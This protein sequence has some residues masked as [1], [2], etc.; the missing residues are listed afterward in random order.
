ME[1]IKAL[2]QENFPAAFATA[3]LVLYFFGMAI[4]FISKPLKNAESFSIKPVDNAGKTEIR[5]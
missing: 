4:V 2:F 1:T 5:V 3:G